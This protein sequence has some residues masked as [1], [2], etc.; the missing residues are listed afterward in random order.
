VLK[1]LSKCDEARLVLLRSTECT[2]LLL[3]VSRILARLPE[4]RKLFKRA[5]RTLW[6]LF[7]GL[8]PQLPGADMLADEEL[9]LVEQQPA[10]DDEMHNAVFPESQVGGE[11]TQNARLPV[12]VRAL[13]QTHTLTPGLPSVGE[14]WSS[15]VLSARR[16]LSRRMDSAHFTSLHLLGFGAQPLGNT[17]LEEPKLCSATR[18]VVQ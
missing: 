17:P 5:Y 14:C 16:P 9:G 18:N 1:N 15:V 3:G 12:S 6:L 4:R 7:C 2:K 13:S 11:P 8:V 10:S